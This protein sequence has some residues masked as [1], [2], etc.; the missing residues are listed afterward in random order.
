MSIH[1][2]A[3]EFAFHI[4]FIIR[5]FIRKWTT[6]HTHTHTRWLMSFIWY[7][8]ERENI[9]II[10]CIII[11]SICFRCLRN[12]ICAVHCALCVNRYRFESNAMC[13]FI[14]NPFANMQF[15]QHSK[16]APAYKNTQH[17]RRCIVWMHCAHVKCEMPQTFWRNEEGKKIAEWLLSLIWFYFLWQISTISF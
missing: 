5:K 9:I 4:T 14:C 12:S 1:R 13:V 16:C 17:R 15:Y 11:L 6:T 8:S 10:S 7:A 2:R 3:L